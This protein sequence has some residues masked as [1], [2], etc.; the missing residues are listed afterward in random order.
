MFLER[1]KTKYD[2]NEPI[3]TKEIL[4][5]FNDYSRAYVFRLLD[6]AQKNNSIKCFDYGVYFIPSKTI[7]GDSTITVEVVVNKKYITNKQ[8]VYGV[9]N[10]VY[11]HNLFSNTTQV[12][13]TIEIITNNETMRCRKITI[14]GRNI[15]LRKS[16]CE[17][18]KSNS[19]A[20]T[21]VQLISELNKISNL[22]KDLRKSLVNYIQKNKIKKSDIL[23]IAKYFPAQTT[24]KLIFSGILDDFA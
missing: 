7:I 5:L 14:D 1:L 9:Y 12:N 20:Y 17:I 10:G 19:K 24:K 23:S 6:E 21:V 22:N 11:L 4:E 2:I 18:N 16:R 8:D 15:I 13:N 3:F